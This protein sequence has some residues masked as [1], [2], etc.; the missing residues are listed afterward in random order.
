[1]KYVFGNCCSRFDVV[2]VAMGAIAMYTNSWIAAA[3]IIVV[4]ATIAGVVASIGSG[5]DE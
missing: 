2:I 3:I 1:M 5:G 4:G